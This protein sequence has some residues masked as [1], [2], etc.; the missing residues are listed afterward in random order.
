VKKAFTMVELIFVIVILGILASVAIPK[1]AATRDDAMVVRLQ[2]NL[3]TVIK[4]IMTTVLAQ[5]GADESL[6][7]ISS[8]LNTMV[9]SGDATIS[10]DIVNIKSGAQNNC[11]V[12]DVNVSRDV[13][14]D[15]DYTA[16]TDSNCK[17]FQRLADVENYQLKIRGTNVVY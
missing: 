3:K 15:I 6:T 16:T 7:E 4:E 10:N 12:L 8:M 17:A 14:I 1:L 2:A 13:V 9:K 11:I 5:G